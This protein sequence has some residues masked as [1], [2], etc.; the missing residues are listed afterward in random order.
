MRHPETDWLSFSVTIIL[1]L[2]VC[3]TVFLSPDS[4]SQVIPVFYASI[5]ENLGILYIWFG[6][7]LVGVLLWLAIGRFGSVV[8]GDKNEKPEFSDFSWI[9]MLFCAG[10]SAG[11]IYWSVIEWAYYYQSPPNGIGPYTTEAAEWAASYGIFHWGLTGWSFFCFS[12]LAISYPYHVHNAPYLR[13][14]TAFRG[15]LGNNVEESRT[16]RF[17]DFLFILNLIGATGTSLGLATP[18]LAAIMSKVAGIQHNYIL[19]V[20]MVILCVSVFATSAFLGLEKGYKRM[21]DANLAVAFVLLLF[22][23]LTGPT[24][25]ILKSGTNSIGLVLQ[26]F[27][28]MNTWTDPIVNSGFVENWTVFYW[29]WWLAYAPFVGI[30]ITRISRGRSIR[31]LILGVTVFGS[32]GSSIFFI[33]FGNYA[34]HLELSDVLPISEM[35][36]EV[37][38]ATVIVEVFSTMLLSDFALI[39]LLVVTIIFIA[40]TYDSA[41]YTLASASTRYLR[42][43]S[44]P[45]R[46]SRVFWA[47]ALGIVPIALMFIGDL[48]TMQSASLIVSIP[49]LFVGMMMLKSLIKQLNEDNT[50]DNK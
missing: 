38:G 20:C 16:G 22:V 45:A 11:L 43:K 41:S 3:L 4:V 31:G 36:K 9:A 26:N 10:I 25:F 24:L 7:I 50:I 8:L 6:N 49:L 39:A 23:L 5:S 34:M 29:A 14:S 42:S 30:F 32:L 1:L 44:H 13:L 37:G 46:W 48:K 21:A 35:I 40:T 17:I 18:M 47:C 19:E 27:I 15:L 12:A 2:L 33:I 28:R